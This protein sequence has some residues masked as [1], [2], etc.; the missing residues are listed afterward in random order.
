MRMSVLVTVITPCYNSASTIEAT[1]TSVLTQIYEP[2]EY[3][4]MDGGSNDGTLD[5]VRQYQAK[6]TL[7]SEP[8]HG[9][10]DAINKGW[11]RA[12]GDILAWLNADDQ[13]LPSTVTNAV[14]YFET[15]PSAK[16]IYGIAE[17][18]DETGKQFPFRMGQETWSYGRLLTEGCFINQP[19]VFLRREI[20]EEFGYI[21]DNLHFSMDYEYWLRIGGKYPPHYVPSLKVRVIRTRAT[22]T[23][24]GGLHRLREIENL[25]R[26]YGASDLPHTM[27]HEWAVASIES[28]VRNIKRG[29]WSDATTDFRQIWR[30]PRTLP[31]AAVKL[32]IRSMIPRWLETRLRQVF[33]HDKT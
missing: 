22:K 3:I 14:H 10:S 30:Y 7:V 16:W 15:H 21:D 19:S 18:I 23:E 26:H 17:S 6:L 4:V 1:I 25:V 31:R 9:Q 20:I 12:K 11:Q 5:I 33:V 27:Q 13:Y 24:S 28:L 29:S 32:L 2:I 8:D